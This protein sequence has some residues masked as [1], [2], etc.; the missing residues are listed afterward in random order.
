MDPR[1]DELR[2][3]QP[4]C[5]IILRPD[6]E[7]S[8]AFRNSQNMKAYYGVSI[9][10]Q[11]IDGHPYIVLNNKDGHVP[12]DSADAD[13]H[14]QSHKISSGKSKNKPSTVRNIREE[15]SLPEN[16]YAPTTKNGQYIYSGNGISDIKDLQKTRCLLNFQ[17]HP[18]ILKPYDPKEHIVNVEND[19]LSVTNDCL[20]H[21]DRNPKKDAKPQVNVHKGFSIKNTSIKSIAN[22]THVN[23]SAMQEDQHESLPYNPSITSS[24]SDKFTSDS[25]S[26]SSGS[27]YSNNYTVPVQQSKT[28]PDVLPFR[29]QDS[30]GPIL[31]GSRSRRSS[32]S[33]TATS[34]HSMQKFWLDDQEDALYADNVNRHEN[35]R[36]I[37]FVPGTGRDIDTGPIPG[38]DQLI[39]KFDTN[40]PQRRGR[41]A[42]RNRINPDDRK[43]S[44]SVDSAF[45]FGIQSNSDYLNEFSKNLGKSN[46]HLLKP[47]QICQQK[48]HPQNYKLPFKRQNTAGNLSTANLSLEETKQKHVG[49]LPYRKQHKFTNDDVDSVKLNTSKLPTQ[50]KINADIKTQKCTLQLKDSI[51]ASSEVVTRKI[52]VKA[53]SAAPDSQVTPDL[54]EGQQQLAQQTNEETAKQILFNYLKEGSPDNDDATKR[55][56]NLVFEKIQTLKSRASGTVKVSDPSVD[57][58]ALLEEKGVFEKKISNLQKKLDEEIKNRDNSKEERFKT[59]ANMKEVQE[60]LE[61]SMQENIVLRQQLGESEKELRK[62]LEE[63]FQLKMEQEQYQTEIRDLQEQLSEMHD[64][65]DDAKCFVVDGERESIIEE[66]SQMK[67]G[68]QE[69][70][71]AK[72]EQEELLKKRERELT[73]LKG[74]L[75]EEVSTHDQEIDKLKEQY[76]KELRKVHSSLEEAVKSSSII[77]GKV[78]EASQQKSAAEY[79]VKSLLQENDELRKKIQRLEAKIAE[80]SQEI[81]ELNEDND[82]MKERLKCS[83]KEKQQ[84]TDD[85]ENASER[86][87]D[88]LQITRKLESQLEDNKRNL[89]R[90]TYEHQQ[91]SE[92]L[93]EE[94]N[95]KEQLRNLKNEME[96][97]RWQLD[98][99]IEKL[100]KEISEN[101]AFSRTS[102]VELQKQFDDYKEKHRRDVSELQRQLK[103]KTL[104]LEKSHQTTKK[105]QDEVHHLEENLQDHQRAHD[106]SLTKNHLLQQ[107]IKDLQY[108]LDT[109]TYMKDDRVR[110]IKSME[111]K[112]SQLEMELDE[113]K[114]NSDLLLERIG[115][116]RE[117]VRRLRSEIYQERATKTGLECDKLS[118]EEDRSFLFCNKDLKSRIAASEN[119]LRSNKEGLVVQMEARIT[120]LEERLENEERDRSSLQLNNRR[121]ERKVKELLMQVDDEHLTLTDQKDQLSLRLKSMKRQ[122]E[123]AE[124]EIDRLEGAKK[125]LQRDLEE[126]ID[127]NE[128]LEGQLNAAKKELSRRRTSPNKMLSDLGDD[129]DDF[130]TDGES[131]YDAAP[132]Y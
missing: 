68:V 27:P 1:L 72:E 62:H 50:S 84:L 41:S 24:P 9:R 122:V 59:K 92:R 69:I 131:L 80:L 58:K 119:S 63:L 6:D 42:R 10:V 51:S 78:D 57:V 115:R 116:C 109:K 60:Q 81:K 21:T 105:L 20:L 110:Q 93:K 18:E 31:E 15:L 123:E 11:G 8:R 52:S 32:C 17:K 7:Q 25:F 46:E 96:S 75:K 30:A 128:Q 126:Q 82:R 26:S 29:R 87:K 44:R 77:A 100:Q 106:E 65:L 19:Q 49:S 54:L 129:D 28:K 95:Q 112:V 5:G 97:E 117:Q 3:V 88:A 45:P 85:L 39:E 2:Y 37:P 94:A 34:S 56:V 125:K 36:Y 107:T 70:L 124:E 23:S 61:R 40:V 71:M 86:E 67:Q 83:E 53:Q 89:S 91:L 113:E 132:M 55:K 66:L 48:P 47:S 64:E 103:D 33:S 4:D 121:L 98:K 114:N 79:R 35:R 90:I 104:E 76:E 38:I 118:L 16:P 99:T 73:A 22:D 130:S 13:I 108:E 14:H 120:E 12:S 127:Q 74:A 102:T 43:R 111:D 101:V